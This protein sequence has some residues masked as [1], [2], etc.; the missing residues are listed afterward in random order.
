MKKLVFLVFLVHC[1]AFGQSAKKTNK[2][3]LAQYAQEQ[4]KQDSAYAIFKQSDRVHDSLMKAI[5]KKSE[6]LKSDE[7][8][9]KRLIFDVHELTGSL[10]ALQV[11]MGPL[12]SRNFGYDEIPHLREFM[13]PMKKMIN[14]EVRFE[15]VSG[16]LSL[17]G[18][19]K[20]AQNDLLREKIRA[21]EASSQTN[22]ARQQQL[23]VKNQKMLGIAATMDSLVS[24]FGTLN[25]ELES[26]KQTLYAKWTEARKNY[27][28][29]GPKG[30]PEAYEQFFGDAFPETKMVTEQ[31]GSSDG[32]GDPV[33][34]PGPLPVDRIE[35]E[36][37]TVLDEPASFPGGMTA[38][39]AYLG[40]NLNYPESLKETGISGKV[41]VKFVVSET[42]EIS[43]VKIMKGLAGCKECDME[44]VRAIKGMPKWIPGK[45]KGKAVKS[46]FNLPVNFSN[47]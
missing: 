14:T 32:F 25:G 47:Q 38:L 44:V 26:A 16:E 8:T 24:T 36:I 4:Q 40:K 45:N 11:D 5:D 20:K 13:R 33:P 7:R 28:Q 46:Y 30:F 31:F 23:V 12:A 1:T 6:Q 2:R 35:N 22:A 27:V 17:D 37:L 10:K 19:K 21:Y 9:A 39:M 41:F 43:D 29:K 15:P 34:T 3:L 18:L 42:G